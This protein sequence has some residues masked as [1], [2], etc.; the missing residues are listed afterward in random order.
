[1]PQ[2]CVLVVDDNAINVLVAQRTI[3]QWNYSVITAADGK[4][5]IE[6]W[7]QHSPDVILMDLHMPV[8]NG[9]EAAEQ[10]GQYEAAQQLKHTPIIALTADAETETREQAIRAGM[11]DV[12]TKPFDREILQQTLIRHCSPADGQQS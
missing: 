3:E 1:V 9:M 8:M 4:Q 5:A 2:S 11:V 10:I 12:L 6:A 7:R